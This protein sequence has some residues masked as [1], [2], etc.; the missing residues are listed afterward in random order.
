MSYI[1]DLALPQT[2][3]N[4][5]S[6]F[7]NARICA[8]VPIDI[9]TVWISS[10]ILLLARFRFASYWVHVCKN[11]SLELKVTYSILSSM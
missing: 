3:F 11:K 2:F 6:M 4:V 5:L 7:A 8:A 9:A 10:H 1:R